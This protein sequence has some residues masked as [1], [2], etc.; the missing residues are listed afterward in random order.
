MLVALVFCKSL[1]LRDGRRYAL[2]C[3]MLLA[4]SGCAPSD[5]DL[6]LACQGT[7]HVI[8]GK[9]E[10]PHEVGTRT[11][12]THRSYGF[13][14]KKF[15]GEHACQVWTASEIR[16]ET[17]LPDGT[18]YQLLKIDRVKNELKDQIYKNQ[19]AVA[20]ETLFDATCDVLRD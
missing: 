9:S 18:F 2:L 12:D 5:G 7:K 11:S 1:C 17:A 20:E 14:D 13:T 4:L 3:A 15:K 16:C 6:K 19:N 8:H 10:A